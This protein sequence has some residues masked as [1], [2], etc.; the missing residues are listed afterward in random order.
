MI[1]QESHRATGHLALWPPRAWKVPFLLTIAVVMSVLVGRQ[2]ED[3]QTRD[4][5]F[6]VHL[7]PRLMAAGHRPGH[8]GHRLSQA[9]R[10]TAHGVAH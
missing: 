4:I 10:C 6:L 7:I 5:T 9:G 1:R 2:A 8:L 3:P